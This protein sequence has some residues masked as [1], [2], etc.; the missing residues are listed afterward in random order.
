LHDRAIR[1]ALGYPLV[2]IPFSDGG[3]SE[4]NQ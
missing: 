3:K 2:F 1:A 4:T